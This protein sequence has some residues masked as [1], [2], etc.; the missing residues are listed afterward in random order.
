VDLIGTTAVAPA[1]ADDLGSED[2]IF[3]KRDGSS[4]KLDLH[5]LLRDYQSAGAGW[6]WSWNERKVSCW[7]SDI[8]Y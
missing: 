7:T 3:Q 8:T 1:E 2:G 5:S 4:S 6:S